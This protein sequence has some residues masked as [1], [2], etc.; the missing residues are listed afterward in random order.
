MTLDFTKE[1]AAKKIILSA[2]TLNDYFKTHTDQNLTY[3][4]KGKVVSF[5][6]SADLDVT[7]KIHLWSLI[8]RQPFRRDRE[9]RGTWRES[10]S[11]RAH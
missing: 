9:D 6:L 8:P 3:R 11:Q 10:G 7:G 4:V 5:L 1:D 2:E